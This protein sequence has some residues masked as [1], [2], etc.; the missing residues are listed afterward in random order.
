MSKLVLFVGDSIT[1]CIRKRE[2]DA[3]LGY[4]YACM[5]AGQ[6]GCEYP[7]DYRFLNRGISGNTSVDVYA[8]LEKD[9]LQLKPDYIS[10]LMGIND[11]W[12]TA[13]GETHG[14]SV[15]KFERVY[16]MVISEVLEALPNVKIMLLAPFVLEGSATCDTEEVPNRHQVLFE[17]TPKREAV[18]K[19]IAEKYGLPFVSLQEA[20]DKARKTAPDSHWIKDGIHP[21]A[22]G[23]CLIKNEWIK[24]FETIR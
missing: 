9:V 11:L 19:R 8:R 14:I 16:D 4:G 17:E 5:A 3:S 15:E 10:F 23:H 2:E 7:V 12:Y 21:T 22:A 13:D 6:I 18:V 20:F 24:A 1:D